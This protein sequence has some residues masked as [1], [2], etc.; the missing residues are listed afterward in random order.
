[1]SE[2]R[3]SQNIVC[4]NP[5][6]ARCITRRMLVEDGCRWC[7]GEDAARTDPNA[8]PDEGKTC[9]GDHYQMRP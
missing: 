2:D 9:G 1:M 5:N 3:G 4:P 7:R 6:C 8:H